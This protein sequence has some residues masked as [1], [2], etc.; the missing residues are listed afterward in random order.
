MKSY[1]EQLI[2]LQLVKPGDRVYATES[3]PGYLWGWGTFS[4]FQTEGYALPIVWVNFD[5]GG[6][7]GAYATRITEWKPAEG[8]T[9]EDV[10]DP[11]CEV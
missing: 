8:R 2:D 10:N 5:R 1:I 9:Q 3:E 7:W 4:R 6:L 11:S